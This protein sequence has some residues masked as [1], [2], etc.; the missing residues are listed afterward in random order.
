MTSETINDSKILWEYQHVHHKVSEADCIFVLG[1]HDIRVAE[2]AA[3][4]YLQGMA[5][6][7]IFSGGLGNLTEGVWDEPEADKFSKIAIKMGVP[8]TAILIENKSTNTGENVRFSYELMKANKLSP[9]K[10]ILVQKPYMER[11]TYATFKKQWPGS[12]VEIIVTSPQLSFDQYP[13]ALISMEDVTN[14]MVGDLQRI[15]LYSA[16]GFQIPQEIPDD[17]WNAY[18]KLVEAG[19][20]SNMLSDV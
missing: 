7:I 9:K 18:L 19:F 11:R 20:T 13:N 15:K 5:P 4:L 2:R 8:S 6:I 3:E 12:A 1:S 16:K 10:M 17:V 14:I